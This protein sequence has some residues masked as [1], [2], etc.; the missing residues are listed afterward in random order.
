MPH[1]RD[2]PLTF[3][4]LFTSFL[5]LIGSAYLMAM[6]YMFLAIIEPHQKMGMGLV[7][8]IEVKYHGRPDSSR[9]ESALRGPMA[10]NIDPPDRDRVLEWVHNGALESDYPKI[11]PILDSRCATCHS[12]QSGMPIPPIDSYAAVQKLAETDQGPTITD[13][14]RV[15]HVHLFGISIFF[16]L[17][18]AIFA[19]SR[20]TAW[21]RV[22]IVV[23]PYLAIIADI[24]SW[25]LTKFFPIFGVVVVIGGALM[26]TSF[27]LQVGISLWEMWLPAPWASDRRRRRSAEAA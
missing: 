8:G 9:L 4:A 5:I 22:T 13:L 7:Q 18:G 6:A 3:R 24:G 17:T 26:A 12:A 25:W 14:A 20:I 1:L 16:L 2:L 23:L 19:L 11:K 15:S 21:L 27:G 10:S